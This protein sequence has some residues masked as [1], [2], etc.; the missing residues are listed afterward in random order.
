MDHDNAPRSDGATVTLVMDV[1]C[2]RCRKH[3]VRTLPISYIYLP[4]DNANFSLR[5]ISSNVPR[6]ILPAVGVVVQELIA[7]TLHHRIEGE[8]PLGEQKSGE[9]NRQLPIWAR[10][11]L[12]TNSSSRGSTI[13]SFLRAAY[14]NLAGPVKTI[15]AFSSSSSQLQ[16]KLP[17]LVWKEPR[18]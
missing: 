1:A 3:K 8:S 11:Q 15:W 18:N 6:T 9:I 13:H 16:R 10:L 4:E 5:C 7:N 17:R 12:E 14:L 2:M